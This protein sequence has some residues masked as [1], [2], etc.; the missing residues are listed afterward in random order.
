MCLLG[1]EEDYDFK[2]PCRFVTYFG[3]YEGGLFFGGLGYENLFM[4]L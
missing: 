2:V 4:I 1:H 3:G